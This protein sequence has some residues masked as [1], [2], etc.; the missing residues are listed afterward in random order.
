MLSVVFLEILFVAVI[1]MM[2]S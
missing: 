2:F 1:M